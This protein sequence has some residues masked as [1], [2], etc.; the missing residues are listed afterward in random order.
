MEIISNG[1]TQL[2]DR[3]KH[4][5]KSRAGLRSFYAPVMMQ[6]MRKAHMIDVI[7]RS[8]VH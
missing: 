4:E 2:A 8:V 6:R 1:G 5:D 3:V 7:W